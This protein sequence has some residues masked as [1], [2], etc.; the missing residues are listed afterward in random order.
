MQLCSSELMGVHVLG[1]TVLVLGPSEML[2]LHMRSFFFLMKKQLPS[3]LEWLVR[4]MQLAGTFI[5]IFVSLGFSKY[6]LPVCLSIYHISIFFLPRKKR[7]P[8]NP[9]KTS[10]T[11]AIIKKTYKLQNEP[12][13]KSEKKSMLNPETVCLPLL[14]SNFTWS[15]LT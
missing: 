5:F 3:S 1:N 10:N 6:F 15:S 12:E 11:G 13:A 7:N 4:A 8:P 9:N 14:A 2:L